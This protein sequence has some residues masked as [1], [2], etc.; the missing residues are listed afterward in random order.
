MPKSLRRV[1]Q[2]GFNKTGTSS[3]GKFFAKNGYKTIGS[4]KADQ[5]WA[6]LQ[7]SRPAFDGL[8][9]DL[10]QDFENHAKGIYISHYFKD[11]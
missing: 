1:I 10:A 8:H 3:L 2:I 7:A 4:R 6:N 11:I 9:F 5:I